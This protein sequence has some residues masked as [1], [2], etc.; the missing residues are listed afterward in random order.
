MAEDTKAPAAAPAQPQNTQP[1][2]GNTVIQRN[3]DQAASDLAARQAKQNEAPGNYKPAQGAAP[4]PKVPGRSSLVT[5]PEPIP[6]E[7]PEELPESL[8]AG[9]IAE[10][11]AGRAALAKN[12]PVAEALED[13]HRRREA[14]QRGLATNPV[15]N[16]TRTAEVS[17]K[18]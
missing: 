16:T 3:A 12:K 14:G 9:T 4:T 10:M 17:N 1:P 8:D 15:D 11:A 7:K 2:N 5:N 13:A 18:V 6:E